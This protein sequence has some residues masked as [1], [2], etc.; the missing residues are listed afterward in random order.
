M[1]T[2]ASLQ[3]YKQRNT[4]AWVLRWKMVVANTLQQTAVVR[5]TKKKLPFDTWVNGIHTIVRLKSFQIVEM[6]KNDQNFWNDTWTPV[7]TELKIYRAPKI[8]TLPKYNDT[9]NCLY[10]MVYS[11]CT[12]ADVNTCTLEICFGQFSSNEI[13]AKKRFVGFL[14][15]KSWS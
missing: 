6:L 11:K 4:F 15:W 12:V 7:K 14:M 3:V 2:F 5:I 8:E 10:R 1:N 13:A 9:I